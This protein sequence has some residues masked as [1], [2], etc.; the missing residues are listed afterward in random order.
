MSKK[1]VL[2]SEE[3]KEENGKLLG[4][5]IKIVEDKKK[6]NYVNHVNTADGKFVQFGVS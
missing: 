2:C 1:C 3:V 5:M 4:T 6:I